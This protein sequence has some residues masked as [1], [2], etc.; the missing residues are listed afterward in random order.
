[1]TRGETEFKQQPRKQNTN[2]KD[3]DGDVV[4]AVIMK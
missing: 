1:M 2:S 4:I 3:D